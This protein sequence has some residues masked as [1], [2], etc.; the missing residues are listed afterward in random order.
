M[1]KIFAGILILCSFVTTQAQETLNAEWHKGLQLKD[2]SGSFKLKL[3]GRIYYD[4]A[5]FNQSQAI[6][7]S[8]GERSLG[9]EF[10]KTLIYASGKIYNNIKYSLQLDFGGG[11]IAFKDV[12]IELNKIPIAG[13]IRLGHFKEPMRL[14]NLTS[15]K[16]IMAMER[17]FVTEM[18]PS[19]S[20]G[21]MI[22]NEFANHRLGI[23]LAAVF[24]S[25]GLGNEKNNEEK[26]NLDGR[27]VFLPVNN[28]DMFV[29]TAAY[30]SYRTNKEKQFEWE[31]RPEAHMAPHYIELSLNA[32][33]MNVAGTELAV[34]YKQFTVSADY[35]IQD[36][37]TPGENQRFYGFT[38][39][40]GWFVTGEHRKYKN[41]VSGFNRVTPAK[42]FGKKGAGALELVGRYS[43]VNMGTAGTIKDITSG[44]N[45]H[46][47]SNTRIMFN[48]VMSELA[49]V[50]KA[51]IIQVRTQV[52]F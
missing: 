52:D 8:L 10:R 37:N 38:L 46:L 4:I 5:Y 24:N 6:S 12:W 1:K 11:K 50:G 27:I 28:E 13:N 30:Y 14:E 45:W 21:I 33:N 43:E 47:N 36:V 32:E 49:G 25:D 26:L 39:Y 44:I 2:E 31:F 17:S 40:G 18:L 48:Y 15:S 16:Y 35:M 34:S 7:D 51:S 22:H 9:T 19:R 23:Q 3:G 20:S 42:N 29:H 41:T